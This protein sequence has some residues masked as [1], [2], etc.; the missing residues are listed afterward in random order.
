V[1]LCAGATDVSACTCT[2]PNT[3]LDTTGTQPA[4][5]CVPGTACVC[6]PAPPTNLGFESGTAGWDVWQYSETAAFVVS[7]ECDTGSTGSSPEGKCHV[8]I[9]AEGTGPRFGGATNGVRRGLVAHNNCGNT[10]VSV[11]LLFKYKFTF[12]GTD[13]DELKVEAVSNVGDMIGSLSVTISSDIGWKDGKMDLQGIVP[14]GS[15]LLFWFKI[16]VRNV[17]DAVDHSVVYADDVQ[18]VMT[19]VVPVEP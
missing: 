5:V 7:T 10:D 9:S 11:Q 1:L 14:A 15:Q 8:M 3:V 6:A 17:D 2:A 16:G 13:P 19:P 18:L 12:V 4:C